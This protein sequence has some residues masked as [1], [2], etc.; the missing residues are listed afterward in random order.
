MKT[1]SYTTEEILATLAAGRVKPSA[2]R[3][4]ILR[5]LME[6]RIHPTVDEIFKALLPSQPTLSRTT[7]YNTLR[8]LTSSGIIKCIEIGG[9]DGSRWDYAQHDHAHFLCTSCGFVTDIDYASLPKVE[10]LPADYSIHTIDLIVRGHCP[11]CNA[12]EN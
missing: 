11:A 8:L 3:I 2:Q 12:A 10:I 9:G 7:V 1:Y 5:F 4:A 6:N